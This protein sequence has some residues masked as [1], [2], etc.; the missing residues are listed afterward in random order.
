MPPPDEARRALLREWVAEAE[1]DFRVAEHL[2]QTSPHFGKA[3]GFH[4][5]QAA[6]KYLKAY[7][8][9][10]QVEFPKVHD[11]RE[12]LHLVARQDAALSESLR[13][14]RLL[15]PFAVRSRY[16]GLTSPDLPRGARSALGIA[17]QVREA[18]L[19]ALAPYLDAPSSVAE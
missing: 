18:I 7:L 15:T 9:W 6:E 2:L 16:P 14:A 10:H 4:A 12:I 1:E 8:T 3:I 11:L 13:D 19:A 5:Q 17:G